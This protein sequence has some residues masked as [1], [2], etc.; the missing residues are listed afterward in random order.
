MENF[1][2]LL[3][4]SQSI[5]QS[6]YAGCSLLQRLLKTYPAEKLLVIGPTPHPNAELL[7]S[8]YE[9]IKQPLLDRLTKTRFAS[10]YRSLDV[11]G[12]IPQ[13][14]I[15]SITSKLK[16]F[17]PDVVLTLMQVQNYYH[18]AYRYANSQNLPLIV[19][20]HDLPE[21]FEP[22]EN[23]ATQR[24]LKKNTEVYQ[25]ATKRLCVSSEMRDH[26]EKVY[27]VRG[28]VLYPNRSETLSHRNIEYSFTLREPEVLTVG[29]AGSLAY[30]YGQ[31]LEQMIPA[32]LQARAKLRIY[33]QSTLENNCP[34]IVT[35]CGYASTAEVTW[36]LVKAECDAVILPYFWSDNYTMLYKTH[37]P[38][39]LSE[40][41]ALGMPVLIFGPDY[42]TGVKWGL[43]HPDDV[44]VVTENKAQLWSDALMKLRD[45]AQ[46]RQHLSQAALS[47]G[48]QDF[49][50]ASIC[51]QFL[52]SIQQSAFGLR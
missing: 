46:L 5:P 7:S 39:K 50:P 28:N 36:E 13:L 31:Q 12:W 22:V 43:Q 32:F 25:Y 4:I 20:V 37:F 52:S 42:A 29:Y 19:I 40:Y 1:P 30:G 15:S 49:N 24:Q 9:F 45:S 27:G 10:L 38:S 51:D 11:F 2:N 3:I 35:N 18:L 8:R 6:V 41:L 26:L 34:N 17:Q 16:G 14:S 44:L 23:W 33:S 47:V 21:C 48:D